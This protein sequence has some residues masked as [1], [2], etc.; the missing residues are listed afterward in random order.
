MQDASAEQSEAG[1]AEHCSFQHLE[2]IDLSLSEA[3]G[4]GKIEGGLHGTEIVPQA[5]DERLQCRAPAS[6]STFSNVSVLFRR[7]SALSRFAA[8]VALST[9]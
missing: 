7:N 1:A 6:E 3:G 2:P 8:A 9:R 4:P 5:D